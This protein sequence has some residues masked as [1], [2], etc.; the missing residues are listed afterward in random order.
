[1]R[2]G[3][4]SLSAENDAFDE[5]FDASAGSSR[6]IARVERGWQH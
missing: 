2:R 4:G 5:A 6:R 3:A 1:M